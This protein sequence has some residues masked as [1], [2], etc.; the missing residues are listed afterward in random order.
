MG[1]PRAELTGSTFGWLKVLQ[2]TDETTRY[3]AIWLVRC[4]CGRTLKKASAELT[5]KP[6]RETNIPR[7]CGCYKKLHRS[8]LYKG[9]GNLSS[10]RWQNIRKSAKVKKLTFDITMEYA[11]DLL[12]KQGWRCALSG[13]ALTMSPRD[14]RKENTNASLDRIDSTKGYEVGNVQWVHKVVNDLKSNMPE[15]EFINWCQRVA[16]CS[17]PLRRAG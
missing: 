13:V 15:E 3:G 1:M 9:V 8:H 4:R 10:T 12:L 17:D 16:A 14:M 2:A 5:K 7:S 11:W 6:R